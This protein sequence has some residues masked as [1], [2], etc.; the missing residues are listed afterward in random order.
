MPVDI[1]AEIAE[2]RS[3]DIAEIGAAQGLELPPKR[4]LP[5]VSFPQFPS[6]IC[7]LKRCSPSVSNIDKNLD[8]VVRYRYAGGTGR[9]GL[10]SRGC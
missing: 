9:N 5:V 1:R 8:P 6:V 2:R 7:E 3:R 10:Y 4:N